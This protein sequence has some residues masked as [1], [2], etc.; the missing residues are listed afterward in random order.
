MSETNCAHLNL[1]ESTY[2]V[3]KEEVDSAVKKNNK[4]IALE[5][6]VNLSFFPVS[7][8]VHMDPTKEKRT[9]HFI[10]GLV[11]IYGRLHV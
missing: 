2:S 11:N 3:Q 10:S 6:D 1:C 5:P 9:L 4:K 7:Y 8:S